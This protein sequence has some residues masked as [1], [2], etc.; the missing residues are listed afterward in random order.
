MDDLTKLEPPSTLAE[1]SE[2]SG[3]IA[4]PGEARSPLAESGDT[5]PEPGTIAETGSATPQD[6]YRRRKWR[7]SSR[8]CKR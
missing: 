8:R 3:G 1:N 5:V 6:C 4:S 2:A 7:Y